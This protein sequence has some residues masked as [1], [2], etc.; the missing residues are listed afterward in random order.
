[1]SVFERALQMGV[2]TF[3][4]VSTGVYIF[5]PIVD[6][7]KSRAEEAQ[8]NLAAANTPTPVTPAVTSKRWAD[9]TERPT[10]STD[11]VGAGRTAP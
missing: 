8:R 3:V 2:V 6:N 9:V 10:A 11:S 1:M 4:G 5:T 7:I